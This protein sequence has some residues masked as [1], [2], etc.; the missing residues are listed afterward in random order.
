M[1][2]IQ[3]FSP[4]AEQLQIVQFNSNIGAGLRL[5]NSFAAPGG[6][7]FAI[8]GL[9]LVDAANPA[10][11]ESTLL[12]AITALAEVTAVHGDTLFGQIDPTVP[13][14]NE[15][16]VIVSTTINGEEGSGGSNAGYTIRKT[17]SVNPPLDKKFVIVNLRVPS[18]LNGTS[19]GALETA[20]AGLTGVTTARILTIGTVPT[21]TIGNSTIEVQSAIRIEPTA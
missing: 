5:Q 15:F 1:A 14:S 9:V 17:S 7:H 13:P 4:S 12:P 2:V 10:N 6:I 20:L 3:F 21:L 8:V 11:V 18:A 16:V 19:F